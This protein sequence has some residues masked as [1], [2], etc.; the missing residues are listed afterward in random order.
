MSSQISIYLYVG[1]DWKNVIYEWINFNCVFK[2]T[3]NIFFPLI[4]IHTI[5]CGPNG[6]LGPL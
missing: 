1:H 3:S 2:A 5:S 4:D 6:H